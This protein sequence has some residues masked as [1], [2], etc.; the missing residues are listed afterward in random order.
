[1]T[2]NEPK[3]AVITG[4]ASGI[5]RATVIAMLD[6]GFRVAAIDIDTEGLNGLSDSLQSNKECCDTYITDV[7]VKDQCHSTITQIF[8]KNGRIDVLANIA[9]IARSEHMTEVSEASWNEMVGVNLSGVFWCS[10]AAIPFLIENNGALINVASCSGLMGQAYT[11][12]YSAT[13]GGVISMTKSLAMEYIKTGVRI[14]AVAPGSVQTQLIDNYSIPKDVN[15]DL[16]KP[17]MGFRGMAEAEEISNVI[18]FL[19][20]DEARRIHGAVITVDGGLTA[21]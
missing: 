16:V 8:E 18:S 14:N 4:A 6:R 12:A 20:S 10:Q 13:K 2:K 17:Y 15:M 21:G 9:G 1:M 19:A 3:V 7:A 11:V 5:G